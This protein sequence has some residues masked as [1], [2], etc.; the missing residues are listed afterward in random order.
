MFCICIIL[1]VSFLHFQK[2]L[3]TGPELY[4]HSGPVLSD[5]QAQK[6]WA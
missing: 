5:F 4:S 2:S 6:K 1:Y 3:K